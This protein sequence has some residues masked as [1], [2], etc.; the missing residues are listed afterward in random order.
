MSTVNIYK[1]SSGFYTLRPNGEAWV[2]ILG[3]DKVLANKICGYLNSESDPYLVQY[4]N[5]DYVITELSAMNLRVTCPVHGD[6]EISRDN[7]LYQ[8]GCVLCRGLHS[9]AYPLQ[10]TRKSHGN[11]VYI[12]GDGS[13]SDQPDN[14]FYAA[15][16]RDKRVAAAAIKVINSFVAPCDISLIRHALV[17]MAAS[18]IVPPRKAIEKKNVSKNTVFIRVEDDG[19]FK[20]YPP[21]TIYTQAHFLSFYRTRLEADLV[22]HI[23]T[24]LKPAQTIEAMTILNG[25]NAWSVKGAQK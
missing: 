12:N 2:S 24:T 5:A 22:Y 20:A 18:N 8:R 1:N 4:P 14:A 10:S 3:G 19:T 7:F 23:L 17:A 13:A 25:H 11:P 15:S 21:D 16:F 6:F 9:R